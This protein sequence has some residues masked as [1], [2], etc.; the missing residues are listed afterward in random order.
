M[1]Y[2]FVRFCSGDYNVIQ[3][4]WDCKGVVFFE[5][6]SRNVTLNSD[7][8]CQQL[9]KLNEAIAEKRP[10]L[11][12]RKEVIFHHDNARPHSSL[13]TR[14]KLLELGWECVASSAIF[15]LSCAIRLPFVSIL[16]KLLKWKNVCF[17]WCYQKALNSVFW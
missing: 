1:S 12:N 4:W 9:D 6:S 7:M 2:W 14:E 15:A 13:M 10:E 11:I 8:Y 16:T 5:L 3:I 17:R